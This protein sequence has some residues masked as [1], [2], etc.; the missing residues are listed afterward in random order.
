MNYNNESPLRQSR[1]LGWINYEEH[2]HKQKRIDLEN[3]LSSAKVLGGENC[4]I[5][6]YQYLITQA[7]AAKPPQSKSLAKRLWLLFKK[8]KSL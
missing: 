3:L 6:E 1:R 8:E 4:Q 5:K 2:W 7:S